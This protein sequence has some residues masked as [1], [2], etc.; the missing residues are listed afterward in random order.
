[1]SLQNLDFK[2]IL[3]SLIFMQNVYTYF[4]FQMDKKRAVEHKRNRI[5]ERRLLISSFLAGGV[6]ALASMNINRHKTKHTKFKVLVPVAAI[7]TVLLNFLVWT[8]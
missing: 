2:F 4:L 1:M 3:W 7:L 5:S 8:M 6:G